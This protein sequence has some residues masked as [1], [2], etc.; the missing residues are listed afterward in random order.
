MTESRH[1]DAFTAVRAHRD[2]LIDK[3]GSF[4]AIAGKLREAAAT[5]HKI[6]NMRLPEITMAAD[7]IEFLCTQM[8]SGLEALTR[9]VD[10]AMDETV[11]ILQ[12]EIAAANASDGE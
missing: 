3:I 10:S 1:L 4:A 8:G 6:A 5:V 7:E 11:P 2:D 12:S 9:H